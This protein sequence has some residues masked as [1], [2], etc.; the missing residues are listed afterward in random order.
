MTAGDVALAVTAVAAVVLTVNQYL[1]MF[2][3]KSTNIF[4]VLLFFSIALAVFL[5]YQHNPHLHWVAGPHTEVMSNS[6]ST[7]PADYKNV[8]FNQLDIGAQDRE[9]TE[10]VT[11]MLDTY[12]KI[13]KNPDLSDK[14]LYIDFYEKA[15]AVY[16]NG[17]LSS[18]SRAY[19]LNLLN[20]L[21][22]QG[23]HA[24]YFKEF[25][26]S[27]DELRMVYEKNLSEIHSHTLVVSTTTNGVMFDAGNVFDNFAAQKTF[28]FLNQRS[29]DLYPNAY[30]LL[31][32]NQNIIQANLLL[33]LN[34]DVGLKYKSSF[35]FKKATYGEAYVT[36]FEK[37]LNIFK[38]NGH[39][40]E[41]VQSGTEIDAMLA[42]FLLSVK[43]PLLLEDSTKRAER[44][45]L[46]REVNGYAEHTLNTNLKYDFDNTNFMARFIPLHFKVSIASKK[47]L[48]PE[49]NEKLMKEA[50]MIFVTLI[51]SNHNRFFAYFLKNLPKNGEMYQTIDILS[52][53]DDDI[54]KYVEKVRE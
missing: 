1:R 45:S 27:H 11:L 51:T 36:D 18:T 54:K 15:Y 5:I 50:Q 20:I 48:A 32:G 12:T 24:E 8:P 30:A 42:T 43:Y 29:Y 31:R 7:L 46:L 10:L 25:A 22:L 34:F 49:E 9:Y 39:L 44:I 47:E 37:K 28:V 35:E 33:F 4:L 53:R 6:S 19:A 26:E 3:S 14:K 52:Q 13:S 2:N 23:F 41:G 38:E 17:A 21:Y 40:Y 16:L